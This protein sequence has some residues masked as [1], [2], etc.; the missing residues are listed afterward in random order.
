MILLGD[1]DNSAVPD[2]L[3]CPVTLCKT[4]K[5][6]TKEALRDLGSDGFLLISGTYGFSSK[7]RYEILA[8]LG[9]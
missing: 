1:G 9:F 8:T 2:G 4:L 7:L 3:S 5:Q 6:A